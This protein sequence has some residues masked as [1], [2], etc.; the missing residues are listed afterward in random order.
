MPSHTVN[1]SARLAKLHPRLNLCVRDPA[2][3][4]RERANRTRGSAD[5]RRRDTSR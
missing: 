4:R 5:H 1:R 2:T 3:V